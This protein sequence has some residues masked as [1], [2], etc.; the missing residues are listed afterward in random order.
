MT[1]LIGPFLKNEREKRGLSRQ[2]LARRL[3]YKN[4]NG[5][6]HWIER[7][8]SEGL[9][10]DLPIGRR[11]KTAYRE[12]LAL[13]IVDALSIDSSVLNALCRKELNL[14]ERTRKKR[15]QELKDA[16]PL[17][18]VVVLPGGIPLRVPLPKGLTREDDLRPYHPSWSR[19]ARTVY[20]EYGRP[21][22]RR[23]FKDGLQIGAPS[24][25]ACLRVR[26]RG[27]SI[28]LE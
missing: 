7:V 19:G 27:I 1:N 14:E 9:S 10:P 18:L 11:A 5:G 4:L 21:E 28:W 16:I 26:G 23:E 6:A 3:G 25:S 15:N 12:Q 22:S 2:E 20:A 8:E 13:Q 24:A 17:A